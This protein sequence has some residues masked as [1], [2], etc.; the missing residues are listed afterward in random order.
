MIKEKSINDLIE[1]SGII[2]HYKVLNVLREKGWSLLVSPYYYDNVAAV[3]KEIDIVAEKQINSAGFRG[4]SVQINI[5]LFLECKYID[6]EIALWYDNIYKDKAI[7]ML[8]G[9]TGL[10]IAY[11]ESGDV[12]HEKFHYLKNDKVVKL[13]TSNVNKEDVMY[14]AISQCLN[15]KIYYDNWAMGPVMNPFSGISFSKII[16][17]PIIVS[18]NFSNLK[19]V[20]FQKDCPFSTEQIKDSFLIETNYTHLDRTAKIVKS[21]YF[22]IDV[23]DINY[24]VKFLDDLELEIK[25]LI[26]PFDFKYRRSKAGF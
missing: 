6:K 23:V 13:F 21:S 26:D 24:L 18:D 8:E 12:V 19:E 11:N 4:S 1:K 7:S 2:T 10:K 25:A 17:Y 20:K 14:K 5:Q 15:A 16:R 9:T 22:L 3:T